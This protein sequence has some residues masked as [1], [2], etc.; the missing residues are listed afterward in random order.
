MTTI[1]VDIGI[2]GL[3]LAILIDS[4]L[5]GSKEWVTLPGGDDVF[6]SVEH[7]ADRTL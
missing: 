1:A 4:D 3:N 6:V 7:A 2:E 5:P